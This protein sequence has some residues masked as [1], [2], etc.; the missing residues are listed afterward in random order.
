M[1][2]YELI[3]TIT[4]GSDAASITFASIPQTF[5]DLKMVCSA[6]LAGTGVPSVRIRFNSD[7]GTNY[8]YTYIEGSGSSVSSGKSTGNT[9]IQIGN[10]NTSSSTA[11]TFTSIE[12]YVFN[13][14][15]ASLKST[16][17]IS[18]METNATTAYINPIAGL[19]NST[20]AITAIEIIYPGS[21]FVTNSSFS[22]YGIK[23]A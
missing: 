12:V 1:A 17:S 11:N 14:S 18:A 5:T 20:S 21:N 10:L 8:S 15:S 6:R 2:T 4:L 23:K 22:L 19:W 9:N 16:S 7:S 13:Y 3:E